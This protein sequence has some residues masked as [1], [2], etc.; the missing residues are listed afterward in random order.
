MSSSSGDTFPLGTTEV[1][2]E[3]TDAAGNT[4]TCSF[5][6]TVIDNEVPVIINCPPDIEVDG[7]PG[8][9]EA[10]L[11]VP[12]PMFGT[13]Y[14]DCQGATMASNDYNGSS[15]ASDTYPVGTTV[16]TWTFT[17]PSG[18]S[19]ACQQTIT[20]NEQNLETDAVL[21]TDKD[22][23]VGAGMDNAAFN[24]SDSILIFDP[25]VPAN[26]TEIASYLTSSSALKATLVKEMLK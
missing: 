14:T 23:F 4:A 9:C 25:G 10:A 11:T 8:E 12:V 15:N 7:P 3:V 19:V 17:D 5:D 13:D 24:E 1:T 21:V 2:V 18:N 16:V 22:V 6:V 26:A 20:V